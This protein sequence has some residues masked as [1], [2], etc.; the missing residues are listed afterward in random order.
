MGSPTCPEGVRGHEPLGLKDAQRSA[1]QGLALKRAPIDLQNSFETAHIL[2]I[3]GI[4]ITPD[5]TAL[6]DQDKAKTMSIKLRFGLGKGD[7]EAPLHHLTE[8]ILRPG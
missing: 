7:L 2:S 5:R 4:K 6:V 1:I 3:G 8:L